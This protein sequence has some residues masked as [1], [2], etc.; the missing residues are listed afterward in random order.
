MTIA[1][2]NVHGQHRIQSRPQREALHRQGGEGEVLICD[3][4]PVHLHEASS[5]LSKIE[6]SGFSAHL[7]SLDRIA[8]REVAG[9]ETI[10]EK[11]FGRLEARGP[12]DL[13][14]ERV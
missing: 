9:R 6:R 4:I 11:F 5:L 3:C 10:F 14:R 2:G 13:F 7:T 1:N 8:K 12:G